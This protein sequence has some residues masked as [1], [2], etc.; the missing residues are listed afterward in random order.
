ML[1]DTDVMI[2]YLRG[3]PAAVEF[4]HGNV[5]R[6]NVSAITVAELFQGVRDG[7]EKALLAGTVSA[8]IV[9]PVTEE[10]GELGGLF[11]RDFRSSCGCGLADCLI[12][13]TAVFHSMPLAA[14]NSRHFPMVKNL[15]EPY[16]KP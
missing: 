6:I 12:A 8:L 15:I 13:A 11:R 3:H 16:Q 9:L 4:V 10:I 14:L 2:D 1:V 5:D 7:H